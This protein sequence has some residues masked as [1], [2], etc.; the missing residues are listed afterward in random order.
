MD[1]RLGNFRWFSW[2]SLGFLLRVFFSPLTMRSTA[3]F[4]LL[5]CLFMGQTNRWGEDVVE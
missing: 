2:I 5:F 4:E 3:V 1:M